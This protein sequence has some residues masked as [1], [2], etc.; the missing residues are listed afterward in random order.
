MKVLLRVIYESIRQAIQQ[1]V[2]NKLRTFLSLLGITIGIFCIIG[3]QSSVDS[4]QD[5][6]MG[7]LEKLGDDVIY[8]Q[9]MPW[10]EDPGQ[11]W[12]K[13]QRRPNPD[14][15][16]FEAIKQK[17]KTAGWVDYHVF[18]G[19]RTAKYRSNSVE[20]VLWLQ[21]PMTLIRFST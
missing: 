13:Y 3:V 17:V 10:H 5:N 14:Y 2:S 12:W 19:T 20:R 11:N 18:I 1:L 21:L 15:N 16:D 6:V 7:S 4:L 8:I 9:K